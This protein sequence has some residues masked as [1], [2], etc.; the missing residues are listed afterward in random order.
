[1]V[2]LGVAWLA[3]GSAPAGERAGAAGGECAGTADTETGRTGVAT[4][5]NGA[6]P[7]VARLALRGTAVVDGPV[8]RLTDVL[9]LQQ[10]TAALAEK[11][12]GEPAVI[13]TTPAR[14]SRDTADAATA[15]V[16]TITITHAQVARRLDELGVN[17][18]QV[19]LGGALQ[20]EVTVRP[21]AA[22]SEAQEGGLAL[23]GAA[24][25]DAAQPFE[26]G[27]GA[28]V[29]GAR[30]LADALRGYIAD[31]LERLGGRAEVQFDLG[32]QEFLQLTSPPLEFRINSV[33]ANK[34]GLREFQVLVRGNGPA[35]RRLQVFAQ[36]RLVRPVVVARRPLNPGNVVGSA[37]VSVETRTFDQA[38]SLP[39]RDLTEVVGLQ[40][41]KFVP[42]G[43]PLMPDALKPGDLVTRSRPVTV[44]SGNGS[45][46]VRL[47]GVVMDS[48]GM[49]D[50]VRVRMGDSRSRTVLNG[51]VV[52]LGA[53]RISEGRP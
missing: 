47:T 44:I 1:M 40:L 29:A 14:R 25:P 15:G 19:L 21:G 50:S 24:E 31:E 9:V 48:G 2:A 49:G 30:T 6:E 18:G 39:A 27:P 7:G 34:L 43:A 53:V 36:V 51:T 12:A 32:G 16:R 38:A 26:T 33:G 11:L 46:E 3:A 37:D 8:V 35:Q 5:R 22:A 52:G 28:S 23:I 42:A 13:H 45:V 17:L 41:G 4:S 10:G 20:C